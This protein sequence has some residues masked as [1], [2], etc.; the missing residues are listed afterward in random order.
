MTAVLAP[1]RLSSPPALE[2]PYDDEG[3]YDRFG[4]ESQTR[5]YALLQP[6]LPLVT[7][8]KPWLATE[9]STKPDPAPLT[10]NSFSRQSTP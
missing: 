1:L 4:Y 3:V 8:P 6:R 7:P 9:S 5:N 2:P 10:V